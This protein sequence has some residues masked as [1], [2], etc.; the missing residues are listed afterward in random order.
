MSAIDR[1]VT[2]GIGSREAQSWDR[3]GVRAG[4]RPAVPGA[5]RAR[6]VRDGGV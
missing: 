2:P 6:I 3:A 1:A 5:V 4:N